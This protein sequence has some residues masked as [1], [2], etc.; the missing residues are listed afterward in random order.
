MAIMKETTHT[1]VGI[2]INTT[3]MESSK[4]ITQNN[5]DRTAI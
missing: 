1:V 2:K 5:R 4:E 3:I